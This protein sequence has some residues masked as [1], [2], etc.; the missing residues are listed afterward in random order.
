M[1]NLN[2]KKIC[3]MVLIML[4]AVVVSMSQVFAA[5]A[6]SSLRMKY[7]TY[8]PPVSFPQNFHIKETTDGKYVYCMTYAKHMPVT[9]I[10]YTKGREYTDAGT[11]YILH[12]GSLAKNDKDYFVAQT[13]LWI[14]LMDMKKMDYSNSINTFKSTINKSSSSYAK[15]IK[16]MVS[17]AKSLKSY[18]SG[19]SAK[20]GFGK[21]DVTFT[22]DGD[23]YVS[24]GISITSS[25]KYNLSLVN[26]PEG[27][28]YKISGGKIYVTV[29]ASSVSDEKAVFS[30][31]AS[32]SSTQIHS[33]SYKPSN[34]S[35]QVM[36][37]TYATEASAT[38][39]KEMSLAPKKVSISK[40][41][42]TT[43]EELAGAK[44]EV[45]DEN[46]NVID[47]WTS[48]T[49]P[50]II[51]DI[52]PGKYTLTETQAPD[53]YVLSEETISFTINEDGT[54]AEEVVM[55]NTKQP[56]V[57]ETPETPDVPETPETPETP[58]E[59]VSVPATGTNKTVVSAIIGLIVMG[60]GSVLVAKN[61]KM[62]DEK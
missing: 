44:L 58:S 21:E 56:E 52:K 37:A 59:E 51:T 60:A 46:G 34:S 27:T 62:K 12:Q 55:Y 7:R 22:R 19:S 32:T 16:S 35:Y 33:Y 18:D 9:S 11:K 50:H 4:L 57:P 61:F 5:S 13:A 54:A 31:K 3:K 10:K 24:S 25:G 20:V 39:N 30:L 15:K 29:P 26:A 28:T 41:D 40:Q 6:P 36:A 53:G 8:K 47:S 48:T 42:V 2:F 49:T 17:K 38:A 1:K 43:K 45:K 23:N 14:Y